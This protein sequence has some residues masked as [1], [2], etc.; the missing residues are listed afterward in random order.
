MASDKSN[1]HPPRPAPVPT[2][3][4]LLALVLQRP[5]KCDGLPSALQSQEAPSSGGWA[6]AAAS[7]AGK[8]HWCGHS[9]AARCSMAAFSR[10]AGSGGQVFAQHTM[11]LREAVMTM[12]VLVHARGPRR[13]LLACLPHH[14]ATLMVQQPSPPLYFL[15]ALHML[16]SSVA[17]LGR[18]F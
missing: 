1:L 7:S 8:R 15:T 12:R 16:L 4:D 6:R 3:L 13:N 2:H 9:L 17:W 11:P 5:W 10:H 18:S 14:V